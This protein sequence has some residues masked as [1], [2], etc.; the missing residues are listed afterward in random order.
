MPA[1]A[2]TDAEV[3]ACR[4]DAGQRLVMY[5]AKA[6]G[7]C[8]RVTSSTKSSSVTRVPVVELIALIPS[9]GKTAPDENTRLV[10]LR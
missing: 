2:L 3:R 9:A 5:D 6:R 1:R 7:L 4:A 8:L 10:A